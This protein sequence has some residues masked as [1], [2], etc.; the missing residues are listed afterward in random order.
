MPLWAPWVLA[1]ACL[2]GCAPGPASDDDELRTEIDFHLAPPADTDEEIQR[3]LTEAEIE[4]VEIESPENKA[5]IAVV[6]P[7]FSYQPYL[8]PPRFDP[9]Q[10]AMNLEEPRIQLEL[11]NAYRQGNT[12]RLNIMATNLSDKNQGNKSITVWTYDHT[13][14]L[15][16]T[17]SKNQYFRKNQRVFLSY[18]FNNTPENARWVIRAID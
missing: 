1:V 2:A 14:R 4:Q 10:Y 8:R 3:V 7:S 6:E 18:K 5:R 12:L 13:G 17:Q 9:A 15:V 16:D 11:V